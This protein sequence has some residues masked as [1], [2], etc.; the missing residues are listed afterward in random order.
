MEKQKLIRLGWI[1]LLL[2]PMIFCVSGQIVIFGFGPFMDAGFV[3]MILDIT[4]VSYLWFLSLP[5][6]GWPWLLIVM[7]IWILRK[8]HVHLNYRKKNIADEVQDW[9]GGGT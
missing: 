2:F 6:L 4:I 9:Y 7:A 1:I 8:N 5:I 3:G